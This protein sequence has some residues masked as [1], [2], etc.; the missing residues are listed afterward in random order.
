[1]RPSGI[2][3]TAPFLFVSQH[4]ESKE[5][6]EETVLSTVS[7]PSSALAPTAA[8]RA[9]LTAISA[10]SAM[11]GG[12]RGASRGK[13]VRRK[14]KIK[15]RPLAAEGQ[16]IGSEFNSLAGRPFPHQLSLEQSVVAALEFQQT[17]FTTSIIAASY[18]GTSFALNAFGNYTEYGALFDQYM[19]EQIEV[20]L[21]PQAPQGTTTFA[22]VATAIDLD[23]A[24]APASFAAVLGKQ[25]AIAGYGGGGHYHRWRPHVAIAEYSGTFTSYGNVPSTWVDSGSPGVAHFGLKTSAAA[26]AVAIPYQITVRAVIRFR[27]PGV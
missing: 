18:V 11:Q 20:W 15:Q 27:A 6:S 24:N 10:A 12:S 17:L 2:A 21:E 9:A 16:C 13:S 5:I 23:D 25:G 4:E 1:M 26:T 7:P 3:V 19:F 22:A 14:K 8:Q